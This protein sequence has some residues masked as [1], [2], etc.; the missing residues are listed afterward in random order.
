M[1]EYKIEAKCSGRAQ[2]YVWANTKEEALEK[3]AEKISCMY[4]EEWA[5]HSAKLLPDTLVEVSEYDL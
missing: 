5:I 4:E 2:I 1:K 3:A